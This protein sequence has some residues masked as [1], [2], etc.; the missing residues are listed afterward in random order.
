MFGTNKTLAF[1]GILAF[2][3]YWN[4][5]LQKI[6]CFVSSS[7]FSSSFYLFPSTYFL[8]LVPVNEDTASQM[9]ETNEKLA[10]EHKILFDNLNTMVTFM[11]NLIATNGEG[12]TS[13]EEE[14]LINEMVSSVDHLLNEALKF[15][16]NFDNNLQMIFAKA[17]R[18]NDALKRILGRKDQDT[19][20]QKKWG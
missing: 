3:L 9:E 16:A 11:E 12:T 10:V 8:N 17:R 6:S 4:G 2:V 13:K 20:Q 15:E 14:E 18:C 5:T 1:S 7:L 19:K